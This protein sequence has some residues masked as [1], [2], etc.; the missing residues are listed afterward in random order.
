MSRHEIG[1]SRFDAVAGS[2]EIKVPLN[3]VGFQ[4]DRNRI[5]IAAVMGMTMTLGF[6]GFPAMLVYI[7]IM[8]PTERKIGLGIFGA[9]LS[10]GLLLAVSLATWPALQTAKFL[11]KTL[12]K[13][14]PALI[15]NRD[16]IQDYSSNSVFGFIPWGEIILV[17][18]TSRYS[19]RLSKD[20]PGIVIIVKNK[21]LLRQRLG[22]GGFR[23]ED[24][25]FAPDR[26]QIFIP[27]N[28]IA[29]PIEDVAEQINAFR[30]RITP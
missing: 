15:I 28:R 18:A 27:Q 2:D 14:L 21:N 19:N 1:I 3:L 13:K 24:Y 29:M 22:R 6:F 17:F 4:Y 20:F 12:K 26:R 25:P 9:V 7:W 23:V 8:E 30:E 5:S 10:L 16:G 11:T